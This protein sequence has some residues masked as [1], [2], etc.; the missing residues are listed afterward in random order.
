MNTVSR[1]NYFPKNSNNT[2]T[3][4]PNMPKPFSYSKQVVQGIKRT[5]KLYTTLYYIT[6]KRTTFS[7]Y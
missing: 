3:K 2:K 6:L 1:N 7:Y 5:L 4:R